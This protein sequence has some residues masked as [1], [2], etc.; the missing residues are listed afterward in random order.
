MDRILKIYER[1]IFN[2]SPHI[3]KVEFPINSVPKGLTE[4]QLKILQLIIND[5]MI[6]QS[7][8]AN[9][10]NMTVS[11]VKRAMKECRKSTLLNA[12]V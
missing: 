12:M 7:A 4:T 11:G 8:I 1:S 3:I 2:I 5:T 10:L 9:E 6:S